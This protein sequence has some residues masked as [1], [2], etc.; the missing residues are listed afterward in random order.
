MYLLGGGEIFLFFN[1]I[2]VLELDIRVKKCF[3][4]FYKILLQYIYKPMQYT[5]VVMVVKI[6]IF[7][8]K[9]V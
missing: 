6:I 9:I 7:G 4:F 5:A 3:L 8:C 1:Q 2:K